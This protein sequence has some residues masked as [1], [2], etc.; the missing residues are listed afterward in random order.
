MDS[1]ES[2]AAKRRVRPKCPLALS[3]PPALSSDYW[4]GSRHHLGQT[5]A[6]DTSGS[7]Q[8]WGDNSYGQSTPPADDDFAKVA[9]SGI[10]ACGLRTNGRIECWGQGLQSGEGPSS[11]QRYS[12]VVV[13]AGSDHWPPWEDDEGR[14]THMAH[15][16]GLRIDGVAEC[17]G[18]TYGPMKPY[19]RQ[20]PDPR[21]RFTSLSAGR[22]HVCGLRIDGAIECWGI[23]GFIAY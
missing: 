7:I 20:E 2:I 5:C 11:T 15:T 4:Q 6:V 8:C 10:H 16:C 9:A 18:N 1:G 22:S 23:P 17:W 3:C 12:D 13:G 21:S 19:N 14:I